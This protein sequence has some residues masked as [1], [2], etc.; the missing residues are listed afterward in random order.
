MSLPISNILDFSL[1]FKRLN[2]YYLT[3]DIVKELF[4]GVFIGLR[5][6]H[7]NGII[8]RDIQPKNILLTKELIPKISNFAAAVRFDANAEKVSLKRSEYP[9]EQDPVFAPPEALLPY[10]NIVFNQTWDSY[11]LCMSMHVVKFTRD[12]WNFVKDDYDRYPPS[13]RIGQWCAHVSRTYR[14]VKQKDYNKYTK[15]FLRPC[16]NSTP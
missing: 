9:F 12:M 15:D 2:G 11:S 5:H 6:L 7:E 13:D 4:A 10:D 8:H 3:M 16:W 1:A 14:P